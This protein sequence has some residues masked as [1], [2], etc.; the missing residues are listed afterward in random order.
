MVGSRRLS[1]AEP[2]TQRMRGWRCPE[3][4]DGEDEVSMS[5][6]GEGVWLPSPLPSA[7]DGLDGGRDG[8]EA[9]DGDEPMKKRK[10]YGSVA[11]GLPAAAALPL[12]VSAPAGDAPLPLRTPHFRFS[13]PL[14]DLHSRNLIG[15]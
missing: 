4:E 14:D 15:F 10:R 2:S 13:T 9:G 7:I 12:R 3:I 6:P 1:S 11:A 8:G 5:E